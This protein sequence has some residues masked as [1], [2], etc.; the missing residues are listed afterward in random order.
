MKSSM[1]QKIILSHYNL[2]DYSLPLSDI[3]EFDLEYSDITVTTLPMKSIKGFF[4]MKNGR[5]REAIDLFNEG[6]SRN[7]FL[8]YSETYK[9]FCFF[10]YWRIR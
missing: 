4:Y 9:G 1:D 6:T 10:K 3:D 2:A 5:F 8:Y 7:P